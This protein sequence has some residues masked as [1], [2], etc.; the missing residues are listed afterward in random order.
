MIIY[1]IGMMGSGKSSIGKSLAKSLGFE[2]MDTDQE[3]ETKAH[4]SVSQIFSEDGETIFRNMEKKLLLEFTHQSDLVMATG[5]GLPC[6]NK[7]MDFMNKTGISVYLEADPAFLASRLKSNKKD[8][9]LISSLSDSELVSYLDQLLMKR[10]DFYNQAHIKI[11][12]KNLKTA[13]LLTV[14]NQYIIKK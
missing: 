14:I 11:E 9:P 8:R 7:N 13:N 10:K 1:L 4:K 2:F 12:S 5:G 6:F 3:I